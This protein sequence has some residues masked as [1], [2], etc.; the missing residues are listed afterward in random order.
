MPRLTPNETD[1]ISAA[2]RLAGEIL[3]EAILPETEFEQ[4]RRVVEL[5]GTRV[6]GTSEP[7]VLAST[8]IQRDL[9]PFPKGDVRATPSIEE[10]IEDLKAAKLEDAIAF[11]KKFYGALPA[12]SRWWGIS[13]PPK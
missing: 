2:A 12:N 1:A 3:K 6:W 13:I 5:T 10:Q 11:Y 4:I 8:K 9:Y 7:Q